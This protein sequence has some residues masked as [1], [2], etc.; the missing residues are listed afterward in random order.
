MSEQHPLAAHDT[1]PGISTQN[2]TIGILSTTATV[3][4][5]GLLVIGTRPQPADAFAM[6]ASGGNYTLVTGQVQADEELLFVINAVEQRM[7]AYRF[8][9]NKRE[10]E[11]VE[12]IDFTQLNAP[13]QKPQGS[14][15]RRSRRR[16]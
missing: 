6:N 11:V 16:R 7:I 10:I 5:V 4:L 12:G 8:D 1:E 3:L 14:S 15:S 9:T 13:P 2:L